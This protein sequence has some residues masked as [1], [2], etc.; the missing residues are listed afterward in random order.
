MTKFSKLFLCICFFCNTVQA[1]KPNHSFALGDSAFLLDGKPFQMI[2]GEMHY[3][4]VPREAWRQRMRMAK[5]MGLN[6]IGTYVFWNLHEPQKDKFDFS[7]NND[8]SAFVKTAQEEGLWVV[9]RPSPYV[10]AEWEFGGYPYWL[11]NEK[12]LVVRSK[13]SQY[14]EEYKKY[15]KEVGRHLAPLQVNHGGNILMVQIE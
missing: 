2:S 7:G 1:Q 9:L 4:R 11:Q 15:I 14:L 5:A 13:E 6:T 12:G 3:P 8:I 10:C